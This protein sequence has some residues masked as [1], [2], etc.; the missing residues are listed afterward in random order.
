M[1]SEQTSTPVPHRYPDPET[2]R[3]V[4]RWTAGPAK[5][6]HLYF[7]SPSVTADD[8]WL[9]FLS[10]RGG[11]PNLWAIERATGQL[12]EISRNRKGLLHSYVYPYGG[13]TG[14]SKASP[15]LDAARNIVYW[16]ENDRVMASS[17]DAPAPRELCA[18]PPGWWTAFNHVSPD[19]RTLCVPVADARGF[20]PGLVGQNEQLSEVPLRFR[21]MGLHSRIL[22]IDTATGATRVVAEPPFWVSHVQFDPAGSGRVI[23]NQEGWRIGGPQ[24]FPARPRIWCLEP[25][26]EYR[27][28]FDEPEDGW[29]C[30]ENWSP[31]GE[32]IVYHGSGPAGSFV[33]ARTWAGKLVYQH[34]L[35]DLTFVHSTL[36]LD[37]RRFVIDRRDGLISMV[38]WTD[39]GTR[40]TPVCRHDS[41]M[42]DQDAHVHPIIS[43]HGRSIVFTS[44]VRGNCDVYEVG[45]EG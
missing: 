27:P 23:F 30:H 2:G 15:C 16:I 45:V 25:S 9:V 22:L 40:V 12:V 3:A 4:T 13:E 34:D 37:G 43:P 14:L 6:Q 10:D 21:D 42:V 26:G 1:T 18:L 44:D 29:V 33:A 8:R 32:F 41:S 28:L 31:T 5:N 20:P 19:G 39:G 24:W 35:K 7:T 38:E 36:T 11:H 17:L